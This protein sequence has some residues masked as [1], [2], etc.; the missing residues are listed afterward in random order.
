MI[1][2]KVSDFTES[3]FVNFSQDNGEA[4]IGMPAEV[5]KSKEEQWTPEE[6]QDFF[7]QITFKQFN[8]LIRGKME[9]YMGEQRTRYWALKVQ[10]RTGNQ[11]QRLLLNENKALLDRLG[12]YN[13]MPT[14][15]QKMMLNGG[16]NMYGDQ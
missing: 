2:A 5:Y 13:D 16:G 12:L 15:D 1:S 4:I 6:K 7:D 11:G 8:I 3:L 10:P 14:K 9:N